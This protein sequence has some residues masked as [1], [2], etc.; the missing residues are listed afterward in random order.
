MAL[1]EDFEIVSYS[2]VVPNWTCTNNYYE[3]LVRHLIPLIVYLNSMSVLQ[4][5][6]ASGQFLMNR[7]FADQFI[8]QPVQWQPRG[9]GGLIQCHRNHANI[10]W[11]LIE[12][13]G[14]AG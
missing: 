7:Y 3:K 6:P 8:V 1:N 10:E 9:Q 5:L 4:I 11:T 13:A 14:P 12:C 2:L